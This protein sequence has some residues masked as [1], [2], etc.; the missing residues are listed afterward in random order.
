MSKQ[1]GRPKVFADDQVLLQTRIPWEDDA[2][3][4]AV[5]A[6]SGV[7]KAAMVRMFI[8]IGLSAYVDAYAEAMPT[9][10]LRK[11]RGAKR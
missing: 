10:A 9:T 1:M 2:A 11:P 6:V 4:D 8:Q 3:L 5:A 7:S